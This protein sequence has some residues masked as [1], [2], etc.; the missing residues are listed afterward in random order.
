MNDDYYEQYE[1]MHEEVKKH[2][3]KARK[4]TRAEVAKERFCDRVQTYF[5]Q[6]WHDKTFPDIIFAGVDFDDEN[7]S[8]TPQDERAEELHHG[9][10]GILDLAWDRKDNVPNTAGLIY[11][12][13]K[14]EGV[15]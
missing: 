11:D 3:P 7:E 12:F 6:E 10:H 5:M 2:Y 1:K 4:M 8:M 9:I 13:L 15:V 14:M